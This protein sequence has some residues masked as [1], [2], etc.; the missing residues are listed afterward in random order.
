MQADFGKLYVKCVQISPE[1]VIMDTVELQKGPERK[2]KIFD[3][4]VHIYPDKIADK[5][6]ASVGAFYG[7][8]MHGSGTLEDCLRQQDEGGFT[9]FAAHSVALTPH[10]VDSINRFIRSAHAQHPERIVPFAAI[11][12]EMEDVEATV[13]EI[14]GQG[15][16]GIKIH[17]DMQKFRVDDPAAAPMMEAIEGRLPLLIHCGDYR[18][19]YDGPKRILN[20]RRQHPRLQIICA[21]FG[22][23]SEWNRA[24]ELLPGNG[25]FIDTSSTLF[26]WPAERATE[27]IHRFGVENVLFGTDYPMWKPR[28]ELERF[29]QLRLSDA[30]RED[31]LWNN[32][33]RILQL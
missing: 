29:M 27:A 19:D 18:Y 13:R 5:A 16:K 20:L 26:K 12:P 1:S 7:I 30:E 6:S 32:A 9:R 2:M 31:I 25:L 10:H 23:W 33:Q 24:E 22:G 15:F 17:P 4:H 28:E 21:H 14:V 3:V 11:H 8:P